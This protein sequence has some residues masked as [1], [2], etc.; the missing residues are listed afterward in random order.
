MRAKRKTQL[1]GP[2]FR[3]PRREV[4]GKPRRA[5]VPRARRSCRGTLG[6]PRATIGTAER[7]G[8]AAAAPRASPCST[9]RNIP[10]VTPSTPAWRGP[11]ASP[12]HARHARTTRIPHPHARADGKSAATLA[13]PACTDGSENGQPASRPAPRRASPLPPSTHLNTLGTAE[14][15]HRTQSAREKRRAA[16]RPL[17]PRCSSESNHHSGPAHTPAGLHAR[18]ASRSP[19]RHRHMAPSA[20]GHAMTRSRGKHG[21]G[22]GAR[23]GGAKQV[24]LLPPE[25]LFPPARP[26]QPRRPPAPLLPRCRPQTPPPCARQA[27]WAPEEKKERRAACPGPGGA[28]GHLPL[29]AAREQS[30]FPRKHRAAAAEFTA[31]FPRIWRNDTP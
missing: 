20:H 18:P 15:H 16:R 12:T 13:G 28:G 19:M 25:L 26:E 14:D 27:Q 30:S 1:R 11:L 7:A 22:G 5:R 4:A 2:F 10:H 23:G 31:F 24:L 3:P 6:D 9:G 17:A 8:R 29:R 21:G